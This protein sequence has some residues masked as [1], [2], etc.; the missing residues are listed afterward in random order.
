MKGVDTKKISASS[1]AH[2]KAMKD[3]RKYTAANLTQWCVAAVS[4]P[5]W[6]QKVFPELDANTGYISVD[7][8]VDVLKT[9]TNYDNLEAIRVTFPK[10]TYGFRI[11]ISSN[12]FQL[13]L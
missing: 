5:V 12:N 2:S 9:N 1:I 3:Y 8:Y 6:A 13:T 4:N 11:Y 7:D 10:H